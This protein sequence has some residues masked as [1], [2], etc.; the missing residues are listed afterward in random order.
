M[1]FLVNQV[2]I[3]D[4]SLCGQTTCIWDGGCIFYTHEKK[5]VVKKNY[6]LLQLIM[7]IRD[8]ARIINWWDPHHYPVCEAGDEDAGIEESCTLLKLNRCKDCKENG[9][10]GSGA[11]DQGKGRSLKARENEQV[12]VFLV[13][14]CVIPLQRTFFQFCCVDKYRSLWISTLWIHVYGEV[15]MQPKTEVV[16]KPWSL[17]PSRPGS[18][19]LSTQSLTTLPSGELS[20][21][22]LVKNHQQPSSIERQWFLEVLTFISSF[23]WNSTWC[24]AWMDN[25]CW[26]LILRRTVPVSNS[27]ICNSTVWSPPINLNGMNLGRLLRANHHHY[28][29]FLLLVEIQL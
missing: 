29:F 26:F 7:H 13:G 8:L 9:V 12:M 3:L 18:W 28:W 10:L 20:H 23:D 22:N 21:R 2:F 14:S 24:V 17:G 11:S 19:T 25:F 5:V 4:I 15:N 6:S 27:A 16:K 1:L